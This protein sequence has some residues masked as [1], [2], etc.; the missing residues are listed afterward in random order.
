MAIFGPSEGSDAEDSETLPSSG[1]LEILKLHFS[2]RTGIE[3]VSEKRKNFGK[4]NKKE[5]F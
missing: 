5:V 1:H 3:V 4:E 2:S